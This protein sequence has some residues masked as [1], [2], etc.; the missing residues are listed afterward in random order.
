MKTL[1]NKMQ[2]PEPGE[3]LLDSLETTLMNSTRHKER[4]YGEKE[5]P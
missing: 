3:D 4:S 2:V 5:L 1:T